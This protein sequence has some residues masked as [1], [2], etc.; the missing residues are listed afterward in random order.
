MQTL[1]FPFRLSLLLLYPLNP[2]R[3]PGGA[4]KAL[5]RDR[6]P[7]AFG[8]F[9]GLSQRTFRHLHNDA[10]VIFLLYILAVYN[11]DKFFKTVFF[12]LLN[13]TSGT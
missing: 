1:S 3:R 8:A 9:S 11:G 4:L 5:Q 2:A 6:P 13:A 12:L 7:N 10:L